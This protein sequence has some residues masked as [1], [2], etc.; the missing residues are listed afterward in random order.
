MAFRR[1]SA[2][3]LTL[4]A[5]G[6]TPSPN[7]S[8][9]N[10]MSPE[11]RRVSFDDDGEFQVGS[12]ST[13]YP[14][15]PHIHVPDGPTSSRQRDLEGDETI[16]GRKNKRFSFASALLEAMVER[17]RSRS[18]YVEQDPARSG[19][20]TPPRGRT[21][22]RSLPQLLEVESTVRKEPSALGRV[23]EALGLEVEDGREYGDGWKEFR[24]G[25]S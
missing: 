2:L 4:V 18:P 3:L 12:S 7:R 21:L 10:I 1:S 24:K 22:D 17:V 25:E 14:S 16:R 19:Y 9:S 8:A 20:T 23:G 11:S 6:Y 5:V 13:Q 15:P